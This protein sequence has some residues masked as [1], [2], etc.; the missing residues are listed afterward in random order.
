MKM[1]YKLLVVLVVLG[2]GAA[3][4]AK[5]KN[6]DLKSLF[7]SKCDCHTGCNLKSASKPAPTPAPAPAAEPTKAPQI[8]LPAET[9]PASTVPPVASHNATPSVG[10]STTAKLS[11][12]VKPASTPA[13]AT[14]TAK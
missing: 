6:V 10:T 1:I 9:K 5:Y 4:Y 14:T 12:N 8:T 13:P 2:A 11:P 7:S 3:Y